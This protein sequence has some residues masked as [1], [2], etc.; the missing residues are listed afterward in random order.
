MIQVAS[1]MRHACNRTSALMDQ[2]RDKINARLNN[3]ASLTDV[4]NE[5][6]WTILPQKFDTSLDVLMGAFVLGLALC[7]AYVTARRCHC[8]R[9]ARS[10]WFRLP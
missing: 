9:R 6:G 8:F 3:H 4:G 2:R 1:D 7:A 5:H 10:R